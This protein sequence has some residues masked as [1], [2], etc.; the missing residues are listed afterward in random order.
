MLVSA[1]DPTEYCSGEY[2]LTTKNKANFEK[3]AKAYQHGT[4][5]VLKTVALVNDAKTQYNSCSVRVTINL[6]STT[7]SKVF[8]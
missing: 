8:R 7:L 1:A 4:T 5:V 3:H 6:A 2:K